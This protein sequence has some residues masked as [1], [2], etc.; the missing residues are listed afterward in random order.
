MLL[1]KGLEIEE[2]DYFK[3]TLTEAEVRELAAPLGISEL[4]AWRSP[5]LKKMGLAGKDLSETEMVQMM[6]QEPRLIRRP[7]VKVGEQLL[8]GANLKTI[9]ASLDNLG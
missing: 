5:S 2:R 7:L 9:A 3:D 1:Q 8:V 6:L 4:F